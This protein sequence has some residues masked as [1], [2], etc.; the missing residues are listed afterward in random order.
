MKAKHGKVSEHV[1]G[2]RRYY[3]LTKPGIIYGNSIPA[4]AGFILA[5]RGKIDWLLL[6]E[7][8]VGIAGVIAAGCVYNNVLDRNI[9]MAMARTRL[10]PLPTGAISITNALIFGTVLGVIG[11]T[12]LS[13]FTNFLTVLTGIVGITCYVA[14]YGFFKRRSVHGTLVGSIAGAMPP[15]AGYLAVSNRLDLTSLFLFLVLVCWQMPHFYSIAMYRHKDYKAAGLPV[16]PLVHGFA[17]ARRDSL[18]YIIGFGVAAVALTFTAHLGIIYAFFA[19]IL[20]LTWLVFSLRKQPDSGRWARSMF[21]LSLLM[22]VSIS[23]MIAVGGW[24]S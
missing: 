7:T 9:D 14:A 17:A 24:L 11:F 15:V 3:D 10:R 5:G 19:T 6:I 22:M 2:L 1:G 13:I 4:I 16:L 21:K 12:M 23:V 8:L 20:C 18:V